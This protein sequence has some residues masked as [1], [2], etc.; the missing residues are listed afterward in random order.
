[1]V[2]EKGADQCDVF[3]REIIKRETDTVY[4]HYGNATENLMCILNLT[5]QGLEA[6][7]ARDLD[8]DL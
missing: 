7:V 3:F 4:V 1:M 2:C 6:L 5:L 8:A